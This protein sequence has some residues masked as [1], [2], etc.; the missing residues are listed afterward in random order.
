[1]RQGEE[2][3]VA[4]HFVNMQEFESMIERKEFIEHAMFSGN[5][6]GTSIKAVD[7]VAT[8]GKRCILDID[9]QVYTTAQK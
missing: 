3:G 4:Y 5:R 8:T 6:Y 7:D 2:D 1:M 9:S